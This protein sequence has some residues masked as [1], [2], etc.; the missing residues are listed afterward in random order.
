[1]AALMSANLVAIALTGFSIIAGILLAPRQP[2]VIFRIL[3]IWVAVTLIAFSA[4]TA[5]IPIFLIGLALCAAALISVENKIYLFLAVQFALPSSYSVQV[6]FPGLNYLID[7]SYDN[8]LAII[9]LGPIFFR[10]IL[11]ERP[12]HLRNVDRF[13]FAYV[14]IIAFA[15]LRDLPF[16][17]MLRETVELFLLIIVP[18]VAISRTLKSAEQFDSAI[19]AL[20]IGAAI[21]G[22]IGLISA[23]RS[24]NY[25]TLLPGDV[26]M[27]KLFLEYRNGIL[28]VVA[29]LNKP[30]LAL[31]MASGMVC[32]IY[33]VAQNQLSKLRA[34]VLL[35]VFGFVAFATGSRGGWLGAATIVGAY[36]LFIKASSRLRK[37]SIMAGLSAVFGLVLYVGVFGADFQ[38]DYG[39][40]NY[41]A[42]LLRTSLEQI[43]ERPIFGTHNIGQ[44]ERFQHLIQGEGIIDL[45]NIYLE[46][47]LYYGLVG[48]G[49]I[50]VANIIGIRGGLRALR[51]LEAKDQQDEIA[52]LRRSQLLL[53]IA[54]YFGFLTM[55]TTTS[56]VTYV[57]NFGVLLLS[58]VVAQARSVFA[59]SSE[60]PAPV[61]IEAESPAPALAEPAESGRSPS[62]KEYYGARFFRQP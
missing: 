39:T 58:L 57:W 32:T 19:K 20:L 45:V 21:V 3:A 4:P 37:L 48:L 41:R 28:R 1:M 7:L 22:F 53:L 54:M 23:L 27:G 55:V 8:L 15:S 24:W 33:C 5:G 49:T 42:E 62:G 50:A 43:R 2:P 47:A 59:M 6:P 40:F 44:L 61:A 25:Y 17:S 51:Q 34:L 26:T 11:S 12:S 35:G 14:V 9:L 60:S 46:I 29:T 31:V 56:G 38:D 16:T 18:Y 13:L 10:Q 36:F 52:R 30:L